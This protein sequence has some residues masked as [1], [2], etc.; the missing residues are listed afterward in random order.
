MTDLALNKEKIMAVLD[1]FPTS[2]LIEDFIDKIIIAAK[3]EKA[4]EQFDKGE[5]MTSEELDK[6]I[7]K[8]D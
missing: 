7:E 5:Y 8:W 2:V 6:E 1:D 3:I 4:L